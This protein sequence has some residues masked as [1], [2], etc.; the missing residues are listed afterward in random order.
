MPLWDQL[1]PFSQYYFLPFYPLCSSES[2]DFSINV[3]PIDIEANCFESD[4]SP[5]V[6]R[7]L[8][9]SMFENGSKLGNKPAII[10]VQ[11]TIYYGISPYKY[12]VD[13]KI[14]SSNPNIFVDFEDNPQ[15]I[16]NFKTNMHVYVNQLNNSIIHYPVVIQGIGGNGKIRNCTFY[17]TYITPQDYVKKGDNQSMMERYVDAIRSYD[18]A[19]ELDPKYALAW[20]NKGSA[21]GYQENYDEAIKCYDEAVRLDPN[22]AVAKYNKGVIF[23]IQYKY[24]EAIKCYDE[25]IKIDTNYVDAWYNK[26]NALYKKG[27]YD[28]AIMAFDEAIRLNPNLADAWNNKGATLYDQ[29]KHD[30][31]IMAYK[32][33]IR[34]NPN[35]AGA[36]N[37]KGMALYDQGKY[38]EAIIAYNEAIKLYPNYS[39]A[40]NGRGIALEKLMNPMQFFLS[41]MN[42]IRGK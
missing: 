41:Q 40:R 29:G 10:E 26:G 25:A 23:S 8:N 42:Y 5:S 11:N 32:E 36:W 21:L 15:R 24:N 38:D 33:A 13:L 19:I 1:S 31:A 18:K 28:E 3:Q 6:L 39:E 22:Y 2:S 12:P 37:N 16:P 30:E 7:I 17:V 4:I 35:L 34:L 14:I 9:P 27:K 20:N